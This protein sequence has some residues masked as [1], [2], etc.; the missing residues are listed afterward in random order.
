MQKEFSFDFQGQSHDA[1]IVAEDLSIEPNFVL[2][3]GAGSGS[4]E[5]LFPYADVLAKRGVSMLAFDQSGAGKDAAHIKESSLQRRTEESKYTIAHF[6]SKEPLTVC[7][8]SM[9]GEIAIRMTQSFPVK[10]LV[11]FCPA[12]Y[13]EAAFVVPF[14][15]GFTEIIKKPESWTRS[16][17]LHLLEVFTGKLLIIIG[18]LDTV[19]PPGVI[20]L[21]DEHSPNVATKEILRIPGMS[22][23]YHAWFAEHPE[24]KQMVAEKI[25]KYAQ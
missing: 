16:A 21:L 12:I 15:G 24:V 9:G 23:N 18:E 11:L 20:A 8:S 1:I 5:R 25:V 10:S 7:G 22:H 4:K 13:D 3:H 2:I 6:A 19:I 17:A 14:G